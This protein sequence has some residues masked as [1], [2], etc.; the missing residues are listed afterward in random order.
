MPHGAT[1]DSFQHELARLVDIFGKNLAA[2]KSGGYDEA[3]LRQEFLNPFFRALGWDIENKAGLILP[4]REVEIES[5]TRIG[6]RQK[7]ADYLF[8]THPADRFVCEAKK[9]AEELNATYVFQAKRYAWNKG[10]ALAV[11]TDFEEMKVFIVGGKPFKDEP[12]VGLWKTWHFL[13]YPIVAQDIWNLLSRERTAAGSIDQLIES[14]PKR[15]TAKGKAKQG[16][17][18]KP[19]R[20][21]ALD[22]DFLNFLD[23]AR[24]ELASDLLRH[25]DR[26]DLI[27]GT[28]L[29]E[30]VQRI[31]DRI[32][33]LRICE[34]R[35]IDTGRPLDRMVR[36]W[37]DDGE[38]R[39]GVPLVSGKARQQPLELHEEPPAHYGGSGLRAP[40]GTL[41]HALV[42]HFRSLDRRPPSHIPFFNGNLFKPHFSEELVVSDDWLGHFLDELGDEESPYLFNPQAVE[43]TQLSL[44]LK[45]LEHEN[46]AT[47]EHERE[48]FGSG[49]ALLPPLENN[50][51]CG[52]SLIA[53][54]FS[55]MP[56]DLVRVHAFDWRVQF[57]AIMSAGGF[58]AV[59]GNPPYRML[60][61]HNTEKPEL[62]YLKEHYVAAAFKIELFHLFLQRGV[63]LLKQGGLHGYI[64]PT[65]L[66]N[67]VY[68][69][70]LRRW[71]MDRASIQSISVAK[72]RVFE[73]ADVHTLVLVLG[74]EPD[75]RARGQSQAATTAELDAG[76]AASPGHFARVRQSRFSALPGAVWN[77]L[78][79]EGN[80]PL[81]ERLISEFTP[82]E[83]VAKI[84]RGLITGDRD[85]F[86]AP[87]KLS[88]KYH[89]VLAGGDVHR[90]CANTPTEFVKFER[91]ASAGGCWDAEVHLAPH[92]IV[93]RQIGVEPTATLINEPIPVTGNIFTVRA[94]S[95]SEEKLLLALI[96]SKLVACFWKIMFGDFKKS[97]PQV[98]IF[99]LSQVP[100][101]MADLKNPS[102]RVRHDR[103]VG[104][105]DKMLALTPK[106]RAA[107]ADGERQT[108]QNAVTATDQQIDALV[109]ELYGL[110]PEE[111]ALVEGTGES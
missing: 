63:S 73:E 58:D 42:R 50:I 102:D 26:A 30:A 79:N 87:R 41:W 19:D 23:E 11:L 96:N 55:M 51:K 104:L 46:R 56:E 36:S 83:K 8:R 40:K 27:E 2:Y 100:V 52:N 65:T 88:E 38:S 16:W 29:N 57:R 110:T 95:L 21:R 13:Q 89:P 91:P 28:Q 107:T 84:N 10:L 32:L 85:K 64:I 61:P 37:R 66:L 59:I 77:I 22:T 103:L 14:L 81:L 80:A 4:H 93:I 20:S 68:A 82:L 34:D 48:L 53:S 39:T 75:A 106:L 70:S 90:Y 18:I 49:D 97:F 7:R 111:I 43:V 25:N 78:L 98:T 62:E 86:F 94:N 44:Y 17:L 54:D 9:P 72:G 99:S 67:N 60:Q 12:D 15:P 47:L 33:I 101:R 92:K 6:G 35:D 24:R 31:L 108:L 5:R 71:L 105:V 69:Q 76:F 109:Y 1:F 3:S 45:M 74:S